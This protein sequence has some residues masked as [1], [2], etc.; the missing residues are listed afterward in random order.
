M[1]E[2]P[3][4]NPTI[5]GDSI[6][7]IAETVGIANLKGEVAEALAADVEYRLRDLVQEA[8]KF[9]KHGRR[10][11]LST[12]D[13]NF[14]LRLRN[15]EPLYGFA[16]GE[17]PRFCRATGASDVYYLDDPEVNLADLVAKPLPKVPLEPSFCTHWLAVHGA[18]P[19]VAQNPTDHEV[20]AASAQAR[21]RRREDDVPASAAAGGGGVDVVPLARHALTKEQQDWLDKVTA[22][23]RATKDH[24]PLD[25]PPAGVSQV[26]ASALRS[27]AQ[28]GG[29]H[30]LSPYLV[31]FVSD[32][33][34]SNLRCLPMLQGLMRLLQAML[35]SLSVDLE[36]S[37]H[38][39]M[40][41]V[42]TCVVGKRLCSSP[43]EDHWRLR[44]QAAWLATQLLDR[45]KDKYPDLLPRV[46]QT[47]LEALRDRR[48]PLSTHY[49]AI[50]GLQMLGPLVV[51]CLLL[52]AIPAYLAQLDAP[53]GLA[54]SLPAAGSAAS[55]AR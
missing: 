33:V 26:L 36:P 29:T 10:E 46:T 44:H 18:Q 28:D 38:Q 24:A 35:S 8:L 30:P 5:S 27:V 54:T 45:Y 37:L 43:L 7:V 42:L 40:P 34:N 52:P 4:P 41:A 1:A 6:K 15:A 22:A 19:A 53:H 32:E 11:T 17:A 48:K 16:S 49:G 12:D 13:V 3:P 31:K 14:A 47:L 25:T 9:M 51:H 39:L 2:S 21:K 20:A 23:V 55:A 50:V